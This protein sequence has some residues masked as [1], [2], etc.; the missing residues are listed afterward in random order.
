MKFTFE[1]TGVEEAKVKIKR[2]VE[3][4]E[5]NVAKTLS[6]FTSDDDYSISSIMRDNM[7]T[8]VYDVYDPVKYERKRENGGLLGAIS[9]EVNGTETRVY[10]DGNKLM[11]FPYFRRVIG[12][13]DLFPYDFPLE[14]AEFMK[15]R[16]FF[17][18]TVEVVE[19]EMKDG[20]FRSNIIAAINAAKRG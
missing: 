5:V 8:I 2:F 14:G 11:D 15:P 18:P 17:T 3:Q 6:H 19:S 13:H 12:G 7:Q 1:L 16:D 9:V 20:Q 4:T 10:V